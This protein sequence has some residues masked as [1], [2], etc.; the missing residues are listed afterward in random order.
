MATGVFQYYAECHAV[1]Y[2]VDSAD[3]ERMDESKE[4]FGESRHRTGHVVDSTDRERMDE[5]K[6]VFGESSPSAQGTW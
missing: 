6:E 2:V 1:I 4:V 5:S 3:R